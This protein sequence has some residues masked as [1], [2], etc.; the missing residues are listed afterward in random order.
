MG[1]LPGAERYLRQAGGG[2]AFSREQALFMRATMMCWRFIMKYL[3]LLASVGS[4]IVTIATLL[5]LVNASAT[6]LAC[7]PPNLQLKSVLD[8]ARII[9]STNAV[10]LASANVAK[11]NR[12]ALHAF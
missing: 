5:I 6:A 7:D 4:L 8:E 10:S 12:S 11:T 1:S 9:A 2:I 3:D